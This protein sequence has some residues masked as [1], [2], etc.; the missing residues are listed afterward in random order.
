MM[1]I[2]SWAHGIL[3]MSAWKMVA[4]T[5]VMTHVTVLSMTLYLHRSSAHRALDLHVSLQHFFDFGCG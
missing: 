3:G 2:F 4:I 5:L 1:E